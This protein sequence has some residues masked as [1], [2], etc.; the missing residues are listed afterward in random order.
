MAPNE[1]EIDQSSWKWYRK[2]FPKLYA[3][4]C[5]FFFTLP[6]E[7][8]LRLA[9]CGVPIAPEAFFYADSWMNCVGSI[10]WLSPIPR[11]GETV[12]VHDKSMNTV[13]YGE[14][15]YV[16]YE[17]FGHFDIPIVHILVESFEQ[18]A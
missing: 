17:Y 10:D 11:Q 18:D 9:K 3:R 15:K 2:L 8:Q 5:D 1:T 4:V 6:L 12:N 14:V 13:V 16:S 7:V